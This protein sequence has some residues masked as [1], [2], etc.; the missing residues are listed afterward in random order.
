MH[1]PRMAAPAALV[2]SFLLGGVARAELRTLEIY[3]REPFAGGKAFGDTGPY[4]KLLGVA[5]F[6]VDPEHARNRGIVDLTRAPRN[7][8]GKVEFEA[9][10]CILA[11]KDP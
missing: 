3:H 1:T 10:V 4:E 7:A 8:E 2:L 5:R 9:D 11:P 6:A